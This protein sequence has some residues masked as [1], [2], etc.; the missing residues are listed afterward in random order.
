MTKA[1]IEKTIEEY[2]NIVKQATEN[3]AKGICV[4][5]NKEVIKAYAPTILKLKE[6]LNKDGN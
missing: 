5:G 4:E 3:I 2:T 1:F 6:G